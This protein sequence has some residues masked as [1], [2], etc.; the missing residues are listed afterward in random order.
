[1]ILGWKYTD[2][3]EYTVK[4]GY[5]LHSKLKPGNVN[6]P[7]G[8]VEIKKMIWKLHTAKDEI[9][10]RII[11]NTLLTGSNLKYCHISRDAQ[12]RRCCLEEETAHHLF[13][14]CP[15]APSDMEKVKF[16]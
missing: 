11:S 1:M 12:C 7:N 16:S 13:F 2:S 15:H 4:F 9:L 5:R 3:R 10:W 6:P 8:S 14:S